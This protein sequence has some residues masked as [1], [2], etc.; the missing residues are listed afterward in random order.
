M[1]NRRH[2]LVAI[3]FAILVIAGATTAKASL[4]TVTSANCTSFALGG[5]A[6]NQTLD[7]VGGVGGGNPTS[8]ALVDKNCD[9]YTLGGVAPNQILVCTNSTAGAPTL[10]FAVSRKVQGPAG[11]FDLPLSL[12]PPGSPSVAP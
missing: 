4:L 2:R 12:T 1:N 7:C 5:V 9:S 8:L 10:L 6:P 3:C 11:T